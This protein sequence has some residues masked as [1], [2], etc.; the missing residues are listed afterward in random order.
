[1]HILAVDD[2]T[3]NLDIIEH[4]LTKE[5]HTIYS[6]IN[7]EQALDFLK[8]TSS[9]CDIILLDRM[10]PDMDGM[11][12][13]HWIK[14]QSGLRHIPVIFQSAASRKKDIREG[15]KAGA[16]YYLPKPYS[17]Q[18]LLQ[19][20]DMAAHDVHRMRARV[21]SLPPGRDK[22]MAMPHSVHMQIHSME[23]IQEAANYFA[24]LFPDPERVIFGIT[25]LLVNA[26]EHGNLGVGY[27]QK[28][29]WISDG[30]YTQ[31][32]KELETEMHPAQK[33]VDITFLKQAETYILTVADEGSGFDWRHY[34]EID[35]TRAID[36][37]GR[38][39]AISTM[40][41]FDS[42]SYNEKGNKV[43]CKIHMP[44]PQTPPSSNG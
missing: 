15:M 13:I 37:H 19:I 14:K 6:V 28:G 29:N 44:I 7:A 3:L 34:M 33:K 4:T 16:Y 26:I 10:L 11:D 36:N 5:G 30:A 12:L 9:Q 32:I 20:I 31:N 2:D 21:A 43:I 35:P 22:D 38:G 17:R 23:D 25:E 27:E 18:A 41:C 1:M 42:M 39:I 24:H 40:H 8:D